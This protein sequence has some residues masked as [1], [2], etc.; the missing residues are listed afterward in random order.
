[1]SRFE[2]KDHIFVR[3][4]LRFAKHNYLLRNNNGA[5]AVDF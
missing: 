5:P 3:L 4:C 2:M 1:M